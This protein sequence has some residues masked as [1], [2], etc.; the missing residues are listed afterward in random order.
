MG[1]ARLSL[2]K[3][4]HEAHE[5]TFLPPPGSRGRKD[6]WGGNFVLFVTFVVQCLSRFGVAISHLKRFERFAGEKFIQI[7][8]LLDQPLLEQVAV[9]RL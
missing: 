5:G 2:K 4:H 1:N 7:Q 6:V 8:L 9:Q 3:F